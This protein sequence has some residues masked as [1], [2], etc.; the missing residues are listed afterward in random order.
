MI[1]KIFRKWFV[2]QGK[3]TAQETTLFIDE[4]GIHARVATSGLGA[5]VSTCGL[6]ARVS[7]GE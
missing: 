3:L 6:R 5:R 2:Y 7:K 4:K 1:K